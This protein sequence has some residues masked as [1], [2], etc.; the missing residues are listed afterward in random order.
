MA[1]MLGARQNA[2]AHPRVGG[3]GNGDART[4]YAAIEVINQSFGSGEPRP[5]RRSYCTGDKRGPAHRQRYHNII[6]IVIIMILV[7][8]RT[9]IAFWMPSAAELSPGKP[10]RPSGG[11]GAREPARPP[12][13][14]PPV[15]PSALDRRR[16]VQINIY[17]RMNAFYGT[18][19]CV[20]FSAC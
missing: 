15:G 11:V 19:K 13:P 18:R 14:T 16:G 5:F 6:I 4:M 1:P 20:L 3:V 2:A 9:T 12:T 10:D 8:H 7:L 17:M